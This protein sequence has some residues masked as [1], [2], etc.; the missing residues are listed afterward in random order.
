MSET[1]YSKPNDEYRTINLE[2]LEKLKQKLDEQFAVPIFIMQEKH[3][4][5]K[6]VQLRYF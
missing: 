5:G 3:E 6:E 4:T 2:Q 1:T